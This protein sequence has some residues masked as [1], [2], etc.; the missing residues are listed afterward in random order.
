MSYTKREIFEV[1]RMTE[2][3]HF[4]VRTVT[5][6]INLLDCGSFDIRECSK[7]VEEKIKKFASKLPESVDEVAEYLGIRVANKRIALTPISLLATSGEE[8]FYLELASVVDKTASEIGFDY[9]GGFSALVESGFTRSDISLMNQI[10]Q[11]LSKTKRICSSINAGSTREG[12]NVD[13]VNRVASIIKETAYLTREEGS[14]GCAKFVVFANA[15]GNNPF[16]A[17][18]FHGIGNPE[19]QINIGLSGPGVILDAIKR[20]PFANLREL[21]EIIKRYAYKVT[22][23]GEIVGT[24]V[25]RRLKIPFGIVDISLAPTPELGDSVGEVLMAMGLERPGAPGT[26][27]ALALLTDAVK[28]GGVMATS[29]VGGLSGAFIPVS[30]D[31]AMIDAARDGH[32]SLEKLEALTAVCSVGLDMVAVAGD[33]D[34]SIIAGIIADELSIGIV[35]NKTTAVR[36]MPIY[37]KK[38]GD[39]VSFGGLLGSA[40]IQD[41]R[42]LSPKNFLKRGGTIPPPITSMRN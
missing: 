39:M 26:T 25:A 3:E 17:G 34:E 7:R 20:N 11:I 2:S 32:L 16:I 42:N 37:G 19:V 23:V 6:G 41:I 1:I 29:K 10:P 40:P 22:R 15:V 36:I 21:S 4:D 14:I 5:I 9:V 28:K 35:N 12:L 31:R 38:A 30:E 33:T 8:E 27:A 13:A 24:E 18:A